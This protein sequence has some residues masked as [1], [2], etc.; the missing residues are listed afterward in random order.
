[1]KTTRT[2]IL[3][4]ILL[5]ATTLKSDSQVITIKK[6]KGT[7]PDMNGS[8]PLTF[9]AFKG[10]LFP[11][12]HVFV[13]TWPTHYYLEADALPVTDATAIAGDATTGVLRIAA[14][15]LERSYMKGRYD[16]T[17]E[18][19]NNKELQEKINRTLFNARSDTLE[20]YY[21]LAEGFGKLYGKLEN[22]NEIEKGPE[23][24]EIFGGEADELLLRW[25]MLDGL[26]TGHGEKLEAAGE[27]W[28]KQNRLLG[29]IDYTFRKMK[30]L[31]GFNQ[32]PVNSYSFLTR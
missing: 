6:W 23:V 4:L 30:F 26:E 10:L 7:Y 32:I 14:K 12:A 8:Y 27:I 3:L 28:K 25:V 31:T 29:E 9:I 24:K 20:D 15:L 2:I 22:F 19:K 16:E 11:E 21:H 13:R 17:G 18:I 5:I 1:M